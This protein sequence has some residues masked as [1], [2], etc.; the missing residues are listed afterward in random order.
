MELIKDGTSIK[1]EN[2]R[3]EVTCEK[4]D[5]YDKEGCGA[6]YRIDATDLVLRYFRGTHFQ[7]YYTAIQCEQCEKYTRVHDVPPNVLRGLSRATATFDGF[8]DR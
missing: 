8:E 3:T 4:F 1:P 6:E 5:A 2:W 7:H